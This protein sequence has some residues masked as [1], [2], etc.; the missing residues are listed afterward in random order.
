MALIDWSQQRVL[1]TGG[2]GFLGRMIANQLRARGANEIHIPRSS[3]HD[4]R[5]TGVVQDLI[6]RVSPTL[7][8]HAAATVGGIGSNREQPGTYFYD[9]LAMGMNLLETARHIPATKVVIIGTVCSYPKFTP[10]PFREESLWDGFPEETNAPYGIAKK[11]LL[12]QGQ[13]YRDQFGLNSIHVIPVNLYGPGDNYARGSSH[14]I[15]AIIDKCLDANE[16][17]RDEITLWGTGSAT[18]AF[19]YVDDAARGIVDAAER[20]DGRDPINLGSEAEISIR[21]LASTIAAATG[22]RGRIKWDASMP[23]GQPRRSVSSAR[24]RAFLDWSP[25]VSLEEGLALTVADRI[26]ARQGRQG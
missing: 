1:L 18:R 7:I 22:F 13:A 6:A 21:N 2:A 19:L 11:A 4:L 3:E 17:G 5:H 10:L 8:I 9:N 12:V 15:P 24:A 25:S 16:Q 23:D 20:Y 26:Q 14:V